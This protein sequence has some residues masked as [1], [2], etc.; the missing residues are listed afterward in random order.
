VD[1]PLAYLVGS[2]RFTRTYL[3]QSDGFF[4]ESPLTWYAS[5]NSWSM[6]P[7]YDQADHPSFQREINADCLFCHAGRTEAAGE[8]T[9]RLKISELAIG[10]ERCHGP[11]SLH[12]ERHKNQAA[13]GLAEGDDSIAN[14]RRL[15]RELSEAVCHQCHLES[16]A[17]V[18]VRGRQRDD[19]RPGL[20]WTDFCVNYAYE[21]SAG[22][23]TVTG[24]VEQ[25]HRSRCYLA[26][27]T[28]TCITC[29][30]PHQ[31]PT[32][33]EKVAYFRA[34]CL[35]CHG[36]GSC[37]LATAEQEIAAEAAVE[38]AARDSIAVDLD[39]SL[40]ADYERVRAHNGGA[41]AARLV[42]STCQGCHLTI[43]ATE[44]ALIKKSPDGTISHCDNCGAILVP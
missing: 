26:D 10:C 44:V 11:G 14:P 19:F 8:A 41:G 13:T 36:D 23:M 31:S 12:V 38:R 43:P 7:G 17:S 30:D 32:P 22:K 9:G 6:S 3:V 34:A 2:G 40:L 20:R 35:R 29:H 33:A 18:T 4:T 42:G 25:L 21:Q 39:A 37:R 15:S 28:L 1:R 16:A 27:S 5:L 24:H